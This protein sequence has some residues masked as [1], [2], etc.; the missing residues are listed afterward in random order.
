MIANIVG[1]AIGALVPIITEI[2]RE[3]PDPEA[4]KQQIM[5][6]RE[7]L[8]GRA[9]GE[10]KSQAVAA[11]EVD[12]AIEEAVKQ[13]E[14][15]GSFNFP[16]GEVVASALLGA[17]VPWAA[18]K[19]TG[20]VKG[21]AAAGKLGKAAQGIAAKE[22]PAAADQA[23]AA[24]GKTKMPVKTGALDKTG[25]SDDVAKPLAAPATAPSNKPFPGRG[26]EVSDEIAAKLESRAAY[27]KKLASLD[28]R[29]PELMRLVDE[30]VPAQRPQ[31]PDFLP[32]EMAGPRAPARSM[33]LESAPE[34]VAARTRQAIPRARAEAALAADTGTKQMVLEG[35]PATATPFPASYGR[36]MQ[37]MADTADVQAADLTSG[38]SAMLEQI[39][40]QQM[41]RDWEQMELRN[42]LG[43]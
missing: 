21:A 30:R 8:I 36:K 41:E 27:D 12:A 17:A 32:G 13:A 18:G 6:Q 1:A 31:V 25:A 5:A 34:I 14:E 24:V 23:V 43:L 38:R 42:K 26:Q 19:V 9:I 15:Q 37:R 20:M 10:G 29:D 16:G 2:A 3:K 4:A 33:I 22:A 40:R 11:K 28:D 35:T 39:R 7:E